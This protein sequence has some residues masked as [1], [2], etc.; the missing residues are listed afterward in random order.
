M[1]TKPIDAFLGA[2]Q[3]ATTLWN[4][5]SAGVPGRPAKEKEDLLRASV[6]LILAGIDSYFHDKILER[7]TP[8]LKRQRGKDLSGD[9][10]KII[11]GNG[12][13]AKMLQLLYQ[14][15]PHR[16]IHTIVKNVKA[17]LTFQKPDKI[18]KAVKIIGVKDLWFQVAK[19]M[20]GRESKDGV[21]DAL[22]NYANR[23]DK[24][25]HEADRAR[26][27]GVT[28][29]KRGYVKRCLTWSKQFIDAAD[30]A[31]DATTGD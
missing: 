26:G 13:I 1:A 16:H 12:G 22:R 31:I 27:G 8:Y 24:I 14:E 25:A 4:L 2:H 29:I 6:I 11:E 9:L 15:R 28:P 3:R 21:V 7:L 20:K 30:G 10:V 18:E 17:D 19:R 23:R 5:H